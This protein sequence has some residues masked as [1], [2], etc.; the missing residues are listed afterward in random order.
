[1][2]LDKEVKIRVNN[3][4]A[5][6]YQDKGYDIPMRVGSRGKLVY[7]DT[8]YF[9][10]KIEDLEPSSSVLVHTI[11]DICGKEKIMPYREYYRQLDEDGIRTC[12]K[13]KTIKFQRTL[14][15]KYGKEIDNITQLDYIKEK[16]KATNQ[17]KFGVD[18]CMSSKE[19]QEKRKNTNI[20][21][22]GHEWANQNDEIK[23]KTI[24]TNLEKY[25]VP[26]PSMVDEFKEK[27][28]NTMLKRY[29]AEH[30]MQ[31]P[32]I[33]EKIEFTNFKKYGHKCSLGSKEVY[34]KGLNTKYKN[35]N[36]ATS[37]Q[38]EYICNLYNGE[39]NYPCANYNL[40]ILLDNLDIE[41]DGGGHSLSVE[42]GKVSQH[43]FNIKQIIRDKT[44]KSFGYKIIRFISN[45]DKL[46]SDDI[47][48]EL[49]NLSKEYFLSTNHTWIEWYFDSNTYRNADNLDGSFF[50]FGLLKRIKTA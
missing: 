24:R 19:C 8:K 10:V 41:Y 50:D 20:R 13:C 42:L 45:T 23:N 37:S 29:G 30:S 43:D 7:D 32:S 31:V 38:Q 21:R 39:L 1:M 36:V 47:L 16:I 3:R 34:E 2:I 25:G 33:R 27:Q 26:S 6:I 44:V 35:G 28:K 11:C 46:P 9:T 17:E 49:L 14:H 18:W 5:K 22:Y 48:L 15:E 4:I 12:I 40:D